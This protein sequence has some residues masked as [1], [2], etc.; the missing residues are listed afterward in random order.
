[1][2]HLAESEEESQMFADGAG[3]MFEF[4]E[5]IGRDMRDTGGHTP[6]QHL[7]AADALPQ[8][9]MLV[10]MNYVT[11]EDQAALAARA[12][13]FHVIHCP[14]CH[15]YFDRAPFPYHLHRALGFPISIG[16]D[17]LASNEELN[18]FAE[19]RT[20]RR[21]FPGIAPEAVLAMVTRNPAA[22]LGMDGRLGVLR[23]GAFAD[24]ISIPFAGDAVD[25]TEAVCAN[26]TPPQVVARSDLDK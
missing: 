25:A 10:H 24:I 17:S 22:A 9:A 16:T 13:D 1:M 12:G 3:P 20:F 14:G 5:K 23:A 21:S 7:L 26:R 4:L 19:M 6:I 11:S 8:G 18:L 2:T 15:A